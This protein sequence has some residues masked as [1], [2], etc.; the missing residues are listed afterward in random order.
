MQ[1]TAGF[2][3]S[4]TLKYAINILWLM[5]A[6]HSNKHIREAIRYAES[7]NWSVTKAGPRAHL[8]ALY[9]VRNT[10]VTG[11]ALESCQHRAIRS[12]AHGTSVGMSTAVPMSNAKD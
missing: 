1:L 12:C 5:R 9:G 2:L 6:S 8:G 11:V 4:C 7:K 3:A 10:P